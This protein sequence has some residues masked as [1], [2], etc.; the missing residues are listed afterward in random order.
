[1]YGVF[2]MMHLLSRLRSEGTVR[3][4]RAIGQEATVYL[5][6][7][8][9]RSALGKVLVDVQGRTMEY[10]ALTSGPEL[11]TGTKVIVIDVIS[12]DTL[13]VNAL[14]ESGPVAPESEERKSYV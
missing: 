1:M 11:P 3:I 10:S 14:A 13:E 12:D 5:R 4:Q 6:I 7:P 2:R 8:A 9:T